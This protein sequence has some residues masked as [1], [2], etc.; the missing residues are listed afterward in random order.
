M[1]YDGLV[2]ITFCSVSSEHV[3]EETKVNGVLG[4][5]VVRA[6]H[7]EG[8]DMVG[9]ILSSTTLKILDVR[10]K[11][12]RHSRPTYIMMYWFI[13]QLDKI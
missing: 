10:G 5:G 1:R 13:Y 7:V 11:I 9:R 12:S 4:N 6:P 8:V 3:L 2:Y